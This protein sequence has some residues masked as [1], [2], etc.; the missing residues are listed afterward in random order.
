MT[1]TNDLYAYLWAHITLP[2]AIAL[3]VVGVWVAYRHRNLFGAAG[4]RALAAIG[5]MLARWDGYRDGKPEPTS[6]DIVP[7]R[8]LAEKYPLPELE[9][10]P[11]PLSPRLHERMTQTV[12]VRAVAPR[13]LPQVPGYGRHSVV[14]APGTEAQ[15]E[16]DE[17]TSAL[18]LGVGR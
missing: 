12:T 17:P 14:N 2:A 1:H 18:A 11:L 10:W 3:T 16:A 7:A 6:Q 4:D 15:I 13:A 5:R 9:P 8:A